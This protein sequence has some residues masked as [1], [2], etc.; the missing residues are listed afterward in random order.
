M[1]WHVSKWFLSP[2]PRQRRFF[3]GIHCENLVEPQEVKL[4]KVCSPYLSMFW[5]PRVFNYQN[6]PHWTSSNLS[7]TLQICLS[8][9]WFLWSCLLL[10]VV[11]LCI[12]L[13]VP[14]MLRTVCFPVTLLSYGS[15]KSCWYFQ[16]FIVTVIE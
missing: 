11:I 15:K 6:C 14:P 12:H 9:H 16:L 5:S 10:W 3:L 8:L 13:S 2:S 1:F 4:R 7:I